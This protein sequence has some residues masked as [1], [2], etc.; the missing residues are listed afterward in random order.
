MY[1]DIYVCIYTHTYIYIHVCMYIHT[2]MCMCVDMYVCRYVYTY[3]HI[4][5]CKAGLLRKCCSFRKPEP[6]VCSSSARG[7]LKRGQGPQ[8]APGITEG[9]QGE[10]S[11]RNLKL[12]TRLYRFYTGCSGCSKTRAELVEG[13]F[14]VGRTYLYSWYKV[15]WGQVGVELV[16]SEFRIGT[17]M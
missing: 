4:F 12:S 7:S 8:S 2:C 3:R 11:I 6:R 17:G 1:I 5:M 10:G 14:R 15:C 16:E 13:R 9:F